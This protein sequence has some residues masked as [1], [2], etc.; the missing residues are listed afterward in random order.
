M[1]K[2]FFGIMKALEK[3]SYSDALKE[4]SKIENHPLG[5]ILK[6]GLI[7]SDKKDKDIERAMEE[8]ILREIPKIK[9]RINLL[10]LFA[11]IST[12]LGLLGTI[13][14][15]MLSFKSVNSASEAMKQ[16]I[17]ASGI[18]VAMLT[19]AFGLIVAIPCLIAY[20]ILNNKSE[21]IIDQ[22]E[23]KALTLA[24]SLSALKKDGS[25]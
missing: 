4:C 2:A 10:T 13:Q 16:E 5:R 21:F 7:K 22:F 6:A 19:T 3:A 23:E 11:N 15:L 1:D 8:K 20:Y 12:L 24:N 17:L 25:I 18:S 9:A 14:G